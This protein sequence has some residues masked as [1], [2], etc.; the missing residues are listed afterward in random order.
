M[1]I[2]LELL[3]YSS[4]LNPRFNDGTTSPRPT[5]HHYTNYLI[6]PRRQWKQIGET[7]GGDIIPLLPPHF[8]NPSSTF[9][10]E[11][12]SLSLSTSLF[13]LRELSLIKKTP[14]NFL[15][16]FVFCFFPSPLFLSF[17]FLQ[18]LVFVSLIFPFTPFSLNFFFFAP[19]VLIY[20]HFLFV[21]FL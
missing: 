20:F 7:R 15:S 21:F 9:Y 10:A 6:A 13:K 2:M 4:F 3:S 12:L 17:V 16:V 11:S 18:I 1:K 8:S 14:S 5:N 19:L